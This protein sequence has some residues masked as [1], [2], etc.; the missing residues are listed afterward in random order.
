MSRP[1]I[2]YDKSRPSGR[3]VSLW[4]GMV[5]GGIA[6]LLHLISAYATAEFGC[7]GRLGEPRFGGIST[8]AWVEIALTIVASAVAGGATVVAYRRH[9][10]LRSNASLDGPP[11]ADEF[12]ARAGV[13][14]SGILVFVILFESIPIFF[15]LRSC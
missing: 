15:Y 7:V 11:V 5:G 8:V 13:L 10:E 1:V 6:W 12:A 9:S 3:R 14:A 2:R 4:F